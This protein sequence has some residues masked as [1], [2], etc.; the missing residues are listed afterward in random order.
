VIIDGN[1][2]NAMVRR[3]SARRLDI[4]NRIHKIL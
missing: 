1:F 2:S 3:I 4:N